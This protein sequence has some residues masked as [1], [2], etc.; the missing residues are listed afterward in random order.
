VT[1]T[2]SKE[3][4]DEVAVGLGTGV[5]ASVV[6][7]G[8]ICVG[9]SVAGTTGFVGN[10][11]GLVGDATVTDKSH[12]RDITINRER[13]KRTFFTIVLCILKFPFILN[14]TYQKQKTPPAAGESLTI[15]M[16][17]CL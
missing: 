1:S 8:E 12:A 2:P 17:S 10:G 16:D 4:C 3:G 13:N 15:Q 9:A 14:H 6:G 7:E 5:A 11:A